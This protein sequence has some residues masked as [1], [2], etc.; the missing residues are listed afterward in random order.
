MT[1]RPVG[2]REDRPKEEEEEGKGAEGEEG[3]VLWRR[4]AGGVTG[5]VVMQVKLNSLDP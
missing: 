1:W 3:L 4:W 2:G 5:G